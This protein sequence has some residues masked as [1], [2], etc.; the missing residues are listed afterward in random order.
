MAKI[1]AKGSRKAKSGPAAPSA[2]GCILIVV[3]GFLLLGALLYFS[4]S[5]G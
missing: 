3:I 2:V 5:R 4:I 1:R